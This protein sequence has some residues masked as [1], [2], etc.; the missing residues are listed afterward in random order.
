MSVQVKT[1]VR[2]NVLKNLTIDE[3]KV[4][5]MAH[6]V[7]ADDTEILESK[8]HGNPIVAMKLAEAEKA[9]FD[10]LS[11]MASAAP[12]SSNPVKGKI[13]ASLRSKK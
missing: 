4:Y 2:T 11:R 10:K 9:L 7:A 5:R 8:A 12:V 3:E 13:I 6:G 1:G